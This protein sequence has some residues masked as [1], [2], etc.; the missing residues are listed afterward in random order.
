[1]EPGVPAGPTYPEPH[2]PWVQTDGIFG[3]SNPVPADAAQGV[4]GPDNN[5]ISGIRDG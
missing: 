2:Q 4:A 1:V 5:R 3:V